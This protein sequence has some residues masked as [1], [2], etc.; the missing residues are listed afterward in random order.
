MLRVEFSARQSFFFQ[1]GIY[2]CAFALKYAIMTE[3]V[4]PLSMSKSSAQLR[5]VSF[6]RRCMYQA[7][8]NQH[9]VGGWT[10]E[11]VRAAEVR[12]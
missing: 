6:R 10:R 12:R 11:A 3:D 4:L 7:R 8:Q 5:L 2:T 9:S 1:M